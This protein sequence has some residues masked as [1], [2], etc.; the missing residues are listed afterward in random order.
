MQICNRKTLYYIFKK[1][2]WIFCTLLVLLVL[3]RWSTGEKI[4]LIQF[5]YPL[6]NL[7][8]V[9]DEIETTGRTA[10][11]PL[12]NVTKHYV[13]KKDPSTKFCRS[14]A[15]DSFDMVFIVKSFVGN[16]GQRVAIRN[17]WG[18]QKNLRVKTLFVLGYLE[19][20]QPFVDFEYEQ[21]GD[22]LQLGF[23]DTYDSLV[24]KTIIPIDWLVKRKINTKYVH[25]LDDDRLVNTRRLLQFANDNIGTTEKTIIGY[26]V[27]ISRPYR[28]KSSKWF[29]SLEEYPFDYWPQYIIGGTL[30][31]NMKVVKSLAY[32]IP[33]TRIIRMEDVFI[34]ILSKLL[35]INVVHNCGFMP[36]YT[37]GSELKDK[38]SSPDY[39]SYHSIIDGWKQLQN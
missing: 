13:I 30:L 18:S 25:F 14:E 36:Y 10:E 16:F 19:S 31:T 8:D 9:V 22:I 39:K 4:Y 11:N 15:C 3:R 33:F 1:W 7:I 38:L 5:T 32:S 34:G 27:M 21:Y 37:P 28:E 29:T 26:K 17:T 24:Y 6:N 20:F 35:K 23:K 12:N 2:P